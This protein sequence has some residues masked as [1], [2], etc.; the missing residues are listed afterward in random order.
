MLHRIWGGCF[1][2]NASLTNGTHPATMRRR[3]S[4]RTTI[5][6]S[7]VL[8]ILLVVGLSFALLMCW[9]GKITGKDG[10]R[11]PLAH[12][13]TF[14]LMWALTVWGLVRSMG[15][16]KRVEVDDDALCVSNYTTEVRIPLSEVTDVR[17]RGGPKGLTRVSIAL[18]NPSAL[19]ESIEF[20][21]RLSR[22][23]AGMGPAVR[24][25]QALCNQA[26]AKNT[27]DLAMPSDPDEKTF[28]TS[29]DCVLRVG[30][31][32]VLCGLSGRDPDFQPDEQD[33]VFFKDLDRITV[34]R[35][36]KSGSITAIDYEVKGKPGPF[37][38]GGY[39]PMDMEEIARL[40]ESRAQ[41]V[42]IEFLE[43]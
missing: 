42:P 17:E 16:L 27:V 5:L 24:E 37:E 12:L 11:L 43:K 26:S 36:K 31:D 29:D 23:W 13:S 14:T 39:E 6:W 18:R 38:I 22:C 15:F 9:L 10:Q 20:L 33:K 28:E 34:I 2:S 30:R 25:L 35:S 8:P 21:P 40:L 41:S 7:Y 1:L 32:Y 19:G 4:S 3:L